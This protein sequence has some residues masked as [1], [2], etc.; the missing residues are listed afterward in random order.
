MGLPHQLEN[1]W[2]KP[3]PAGSNRTQSNSLAFREPCLLKN[4]HPTNLKHGAWMSLSQVTQPCRD[5]P[6]QGKPCKLQ[7]W[8]SELHLGLD[9]KSRVQNA[10]WGSKTGRTGRRQHVLQTTGLNSS[11][12][13]GWNPD[14]D[15]GSVHYHDNCQVKLRSW[16]N[17][18]RGLKVVCFYHSGSPCVSLQITSS[19][20]PKQIP[21]LALASHPN[22]SLLLPVQNA[23]LLQVT[24]STTEQKG[25]CSKSTSHHLFS[26]FHSSVLLFF[27]SVIKIW[28][29]DDG[30]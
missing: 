24:H 8:A 9:L 15:F 22:S 17:G 7:K 21:H 19:S 20:S 1:I 12:S 25:T 26:L 30:M 28:I 11:I 5:H 3:W 16:S 14:P 10:G 4:H 29:Q 2:T 6:N 13:W 27:I 18:T 23:A